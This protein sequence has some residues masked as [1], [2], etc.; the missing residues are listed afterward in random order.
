MPRRTTKGRTRVLR[1]QRERG[2]DRQVPLFCFLWVGMS[3]KQGEQAQDWP[4]WEIPVD[5]G[6]QGLFLVVWYLAS[7]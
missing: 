5:S 7:G 2:N 1:R 4:I 3:M 6:A